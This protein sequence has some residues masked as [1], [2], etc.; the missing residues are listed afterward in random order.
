M[1]GDV[2]TADV[3]I[4][5]LATIKPVEERAAPKLSVA[6][7]KRLTRRNRRV[8]K[9]TKH[10]WDYIHPI[11]DSPQGNRS[12]LPKILG[13]HSVLYDEETAQ[14]RPHLIEEEE[15]RK[16][17]KKARHKQYASYC[18]VC[19]KKQEWCGLPHVDL[20]QQPPLSKFELKV[21]HRA[22]LRNGKSH[23]WLG[24]TKERNRLKGWNMRRVIYKPA[25]AIR[26]QQVARRFLIRNF[27]QRVRLYIQRKE[28]CP[29]KMRI[30]LRAATDAR[31]R[32]IF[33]ATQISKTVR[34]MLGRIRVKHLRAGQIQKC[35]RGYFGRRRV[36][37]LRWSVYRLSGKA[38]TALQI[39]VIGCNGVANADSGG[40]SDPFC[41][42]KQFGVEIGR[43][44]TIENT[45][46]PVWNGPSIPAK[47]T[48]SNLVPLNGI[49]TWFVCDESNKTNKTLCEILEDL[50]TEEGR[51]MIQSTKI[52]HESISAK[53]AM[54]VVDV[55][56]FP[57]HWAEKVNYAILHPPKKSMFAL[58]GK[59]KKVKK[60]TKKEQEEDDRKKRLA[61]YEHGEMLKLK[62]H[63]HS[64]SGLRK[65]DGIFGK[66]DPYVK[67]K[68]NGKDIGKSKVIKKTLDPV[69]DEQLEVLIPKWIAPLHDQTLCFDI[70]DYDLAGGHDFLGQKIFRDEDLETFLGNREPLEYGLSKFEGMK[71]K[72]SITGKLEIRGR[73]LTFKEE[74]ELKVA[75]LKLESETTDKITIHIHRANNLRKADGMFGKSD[76]YVHVFFDEKLVARTNVIK[77]NLNPVWDTKV[78]FYVPKV[79]SWE[80]ANHTLRFEVF[81]HDIA[82]SHDF[83]GQFTFQGMDIKEFLELENMVDYQLDEYR[84]KKEKRKNVSGTVSLQGAL[85]TIEQEPVKPKTVN[86]K[87]KV[88]D[89]ECADDANSNP[90]SPS[91]EKEVQQVKLTPK[92]V[93]PF[94][95]SKGGKWFYRD[96][97]NFEHIHGPMP[98]ARLLFLVHKRKVYLERISKLLVRHESVDY[99]LPLGAEDRF[100]LGWFR[101]ARVKGGT[102][103]LRKPF[104]SMEVYDK[105]MLSS[106]LLGG[107]AITD[108][109][110]DVMLHE[111]HERE[112]FMLKEPHPYE[113]RSYDLRNEQGES[114]K[115]NN[116]LEV[117]G[118]IT[119]ESQLSYSWRNDKKSEK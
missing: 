96:P 87:T 19:H 27:L 92:N 77:R 57:I 76:P 4:E 59:K 6:D 110:V 37:Y 31:R 74:Q 91:K 36:R 71:K 13:F 100:P 53:H 44:K 111:S 51:K 83:L 40:S 1:Q 55:D 62:I 65:A 35:I 80:E 81:D 14:L 49:G 34:G 15:R 70:F 9:E 54:K 79:T 11:P 119:M 38:V 48:Q 30:I 72:I 28:T 115:T 5:P 39:N 56:N 25:A 50:Q 23:A 43:T 29:K 94:K 47:I 22:R 7:L 18:N 85:L 60:K 42:V 41:I 12:I 66:S 103:I 33:F 3:L 88:P 90:L 26:M 84:H 116:G 104:I 109:E 105:D 63:L 97:R 64:A 99:F 114:G 75:A 2:Q 24:D 112:D 16:D 58:K 52:Y 117:T 82:G 106:E 98:L 68:F 113:R 20:A 86:E 10:K 32:K 89:K 69:W 95:F 102:A 108:F 8:R 93:K 45:L 118:S 78:E 46:D 17:K 73:V 67:V 61:A 21:R 101:R 107:A